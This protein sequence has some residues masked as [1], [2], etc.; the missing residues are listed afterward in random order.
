MGGGEEDNPFS[1]F[2]ESECL[3]VFTASARVITMCTIN[4]YSGV[5]IPTISRVTPRVVYTFEGGGND[6][7]V[8]TV[9]T[10]PEPI[11]FFAHK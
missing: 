11:Y 1:V 10:G 5:R 3:D 6:D 7:I 9:W 8:F 4:C 2:D